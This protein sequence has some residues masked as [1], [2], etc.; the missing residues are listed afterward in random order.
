[1]KTTSGQ[2]TALDA[3]WR[4]LDRRPGL[5]REL[6]DA[7]DFG[8]YL[9]SDARRDDEELLTEGVL[10]EIIERVLG[11]PPDAY[12]PQLSKSGLKPDFT[13]MDLIA[14]PFVLDAKSSRQKL[15]ALPTTFHRK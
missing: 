3:L 9:A 10:A 4:V 1:M 8:A 6:A 14:H 15:V 13:P 12:F 11:F 5:Y 7:S 2:D